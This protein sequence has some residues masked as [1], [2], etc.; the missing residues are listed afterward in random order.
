MKS[1]ESPKSQRET[2]GTRV[3]NGGIIV[4]LIGLIA[5]SAGFMV[6]GVGLVASGEVF[7]RM[8]R[9]KVR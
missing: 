5:Q 2:W 8:G 6:G 4:A 3:R 7:R 1:L 9:Y